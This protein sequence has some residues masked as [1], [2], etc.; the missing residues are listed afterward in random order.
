MAKFSLEIDLPGLKDDQVINLS[1]LPED[2]KRM[3]LRFL[4]ATGNAL[5]S[6]PA[7]P[8]APDNYSQM[9]DRFLYSVFFAT[10]TE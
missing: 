5:H 4:C 9:V 3:L 7:D 8:N 6:I 1:Q 2:K 10:G